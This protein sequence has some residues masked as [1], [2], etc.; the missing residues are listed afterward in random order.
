MSLTAEQ[1]DE[2]EAWLNTRNA[3]IQEGYE[4]PSLVMTHRGRT[5]LFPGASVLR[6]LLALGR[7][8]LTTKAAEFIRVGDRV[9]LRKDH[10][11]DGRW[12]AHHEG[13]VTQLL[14]NEYDYDFEVNLD[15]TN[16]PRIPGDEPFFFRA[17]ELEKL[18]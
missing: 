6:E 10:D 13:E 9:R 11:V 16:D 7:A 2:L 4:L 14:G 18:P 12:L 17:D 15:A 5:A 8:N 3:L 1:L